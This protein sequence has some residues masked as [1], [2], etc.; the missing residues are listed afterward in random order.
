M[1]ELL[2][3]SFPLVFLGGGLG[4]CLRWFISLGAN[5][6]NLKIWMG[7]LVANLL[8][9][10]IFFGGIKY[11]WFEGKVTPCLVRIGFLGSLT[12][13]STF[14]YELVYLIRENRWGEFGFCL[15]LN[16]LFGVFIGIGILR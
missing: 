3:K 2:I 13:F 5:A 11:F 9:C 16:I 10:L 7:T 15:V 8:G 12:T 14:A 6:L 1:K 4:A